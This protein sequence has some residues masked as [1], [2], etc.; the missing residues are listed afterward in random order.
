MVEAALELLKPST[1]KRRDARHDII[2]MMDFI[3]GRSG[4]AK[5]FKAFE[6]RKGRAFLRRYVKALRVV[7]ATFSSPN[8]TVRPWLSP[9]D[10]RSELAKVEAFLAKPS[11]P[12]KRAAI[13]AKAAVA[14]AYSLLAWWHINASASRGSV[15]EQLAQ[16]LAGSSKSMYEHMREFKEKRAPIF[17][18]LPTRKGVVR[19][20]VLTDEATNLLLRFSA[21]P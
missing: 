21:S 15:W 5:A 2:Y 10:V 1:R 18:K 20:L 16:I 19:S 3:H 13:R 12:P 14:A 4:S 17:A 6:S 9:P 11:L 8:A 7:A